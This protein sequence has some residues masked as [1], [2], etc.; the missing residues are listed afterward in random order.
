VVVMIVMVLVMMV[1]VVDLGGGSWCVSVCPFVFVFL[2][3]GFSNRHKNWY[4]D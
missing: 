3:D 4:L 1:M 2:R